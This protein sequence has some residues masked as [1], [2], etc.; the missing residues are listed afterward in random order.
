[1]DIATP[2]NCTMLCTLLANLYEEQSAI[3]ARRASIAR[4]GVDSLE[5]DAMDNEQIKR[6]ASEIVHLLGLIKSRGC[7]CGNCKDTADGGASPGPSP[8]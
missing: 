5:L 1:M 6:L 2:E 3:E 4:V 8:S 7:D